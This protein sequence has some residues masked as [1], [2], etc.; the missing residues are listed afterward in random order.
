LAGKFFVLVGSDHFRNTPLWWVGRLYGW[1]NPD[2]PTFR[3]LMLAAGYSVP[4]A[5]P[6]SHS[7][8]AFDEAGRG[9][10]VA[11]GTALSPELF[12]GS[13][14]KHLQ[15]PPPPTHMPMAADL[16]PP[17]PARPLTVAEEM[18]D[19]TGGRNL[20]FELRLFGAISML[21]LPVSVCVN[22]SVGGSSTHSFGFDGSLGEYAAVS[23]VAGSL[24]FLLVAQRN[25]RV[26]AVLSGGLAGLGAFFCASLLGGGGG[27]RFEWTFLLIMLGAAPGMAW[28][29]RRVM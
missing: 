21:T 19:I 8:L 9:R 5:S 28:M 10:W 25:T 29:F 12:A 4:P 23:A 11:D 24:A 13:I 26:V 27:T 22:E 20:R 2:W 1:R 15:A 14:A 18:D 3:A 16:A 7:V 6:R 17:S